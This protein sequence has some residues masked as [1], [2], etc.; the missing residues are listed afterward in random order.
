MRNIL[1]GVTAIFAA[2]GLAASADAAVN[3]NAS[4][5][6]TVTAHCQVTHGHRTC[7]RGRGAGKRI[8]KPTTY[9]QLS[10]H[11]AGKRMH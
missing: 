5:S 6:N 2:A 9:D 10:G 7:T 1:I 3:Y 4:K 11:T 8:H